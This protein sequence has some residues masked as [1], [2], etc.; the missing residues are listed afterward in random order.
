MGGLAVVH[1]TVQQEVPFVSECH[2]T[3]RRE[4]R[5]KVLLDAGEGSALS[6]Q[7]ASSASESGPSP[8]KTRRSGGEMNTWYFL[9]DDRLFDRSAGS[10]NGGEG[11]GPE[12]VPMGSGVSLWPS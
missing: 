4:F 1:I 10:V 5:A 11:M 8:K 12:V 7:L 9:Q 6:A 3:R 2:G